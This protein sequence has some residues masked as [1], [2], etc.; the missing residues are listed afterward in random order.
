MKSQ[1]LW[2]VNLLAKAKEKTAYSFDSSFCKIV[3][4]LGVCKIQDNLAWPEFPLECCYAL[5]P[6]FRIET[7]KYPD[8]YF[9]A[10]TDN[11]KTKQNTQKNKKQKQKQKKTIRF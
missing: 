6:Q 2:L 7:G 9:S 3:Q 8:N 4:R 5:K 10:R 1:D 11:L